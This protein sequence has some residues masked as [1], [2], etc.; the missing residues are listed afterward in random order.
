MVAQR[1][2]RLTQYTTFDWGSR[3]SCCHD[4]RELNKQGVR[5]DEEMRSFGHFCLEKVW[6]PNIWKQKTI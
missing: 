5:L 4:V 3:T 6:K 2:M 1:Y